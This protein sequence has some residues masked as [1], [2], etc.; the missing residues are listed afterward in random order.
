MRQSQF[1]SAPV[2]SGS[3]RE[4]SSLKAYMIENDLL[5]WH[6]FWNALQN[7]DSIGAASPGLENQNFL[8]GGWW[9]SSL[10]WGAGIGFSINVDFYVAA[11][12][13]KIEWFTDKR[14]DYGVC[15]LTIDGVEIGTA[16]T[17]YQASG[18]SLFVQS[19]TGN[20]LTRGWH[21]FGLKVTALGAGGG[22]RMVASGVG[23]TRTA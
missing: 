3:R 10:T 21:R 5:P 23:L 15:R 20:V 1:L 12:T 19:E 18:A 13:W 14:S 7:Y 17:H 6:H 16:V 8:Q 2:I 11:G 4:A 9:F 22:A